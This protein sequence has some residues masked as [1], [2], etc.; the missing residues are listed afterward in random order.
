MPSFRPLHRAPSESLDKDN[1]SAKRAFGQDVMRKQLLRRNTLPEIQEEGLLT[2]LRRPSSY[3]GY[4]LHPPG[5]RRVR[6]L[7]AGPDPPYHQLHSNVEMAAALVDQ[8]MQ[9]RYLPLAVVYHKDYDSAKRAF[10][11]YHQ[12]FYARALVYVILM[13]LPFFEIPAW[14]ND[15][16]PTPCGDPKK[17]LLS[18]LPYIHPYV[19]LVIETCCAVVLAWSV[20]LQRYFLGSRFW[21]NQYSV[22]K[23]ALLVAMCVSIAT[24]TLGIAEHQS[25]KMLMYLRILIPIAFSRAIR[26]CFRMTVLIVHTFMDITVLVVVFVMLSAWLATTLFS[27]STLEFK[28]Y[29][30]S[31]LNLF[32]LLTTANN[33]SVWATAYR[34][35]RLAFFFFSTYLLVG[36]FFLMNLAFSVVYSNYKAQMAV[37]VAKRTTARQGNLRAAFSLLDVRH[38]EWI[39]GATMIALFLAIGRYREISDIRART[40][41]LFL[42]LNKRGDFKIWSDEFEELCNVIAKEV[43]SPPD[44]VQLRRRMSKSEMQFVT[45]PVYAYVIWAFTLGSLAAAITQFN[46]GGNTQD[47]LLSLEFLFG[48]VFAMDALLKVCLQGWKSYWR[49]KLNKF[50]FVVTALIL[51]LHFISFFYQNGRP[52]VSYLLLV[53]GLRV[54]AILSLITRWRLMAQTLLIV[55]PATAPILALQFLVC[56][57]FS[58]LGMH[59]FGGLVYEGN[60]ALAGTQYLTLEFDAFNYNDYASAMA[61]SFNLCVVNK[62][63]VIMDGYAAATNSRWSR[64]YFMAF[65]A[66]A[67]VFTLNVVVAFFTEAFTSQMEKAERIRARE[68][69][70]NSEEASGP[71]RRR[72]GL[73][74]PIRV[75]KSLSYYDLYEDIVRKT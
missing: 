40:S 44:L 61:T 47:L 12:L 25:V 53:R 38:Q 31:L 42:A 26:G 1:R 15:K 50:D 2:P 51:V 39:D 22:Y 41:H 64:I 20:V 27:E 7:E 24:S 59:L 19:S 8:A 16:L 60:P 9:G 52:W 71:L 10:I 66:I 49:T 35:N 23:V 45:H 5:S 3:S 67:V 11:L 37:E 75:T 70:R 14:C 21:H 43:E 62:W 28:D 65:W 46:V 63:Y 32:V 72:P 33:P 55:I 56:S 74:P 57:A 13:L 34:T 4:N 73:N 69:K 48:W 68:M 54:F 6:D 58:L 17:Y 29:G 30:T 36:F 18:G